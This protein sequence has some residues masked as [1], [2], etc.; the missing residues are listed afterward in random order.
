[1]RQSF[2][3]KILNFRKVTSRHLRGV[4]KNQFGINRNIGR[5]KYQPHQGNKEQTRRLNRGKDDAWREQ[6]RITT[7]S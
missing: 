6:H 5:G 1:M 7:N 4:A 3:D 2:I